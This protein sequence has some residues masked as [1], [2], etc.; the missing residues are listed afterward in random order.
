M[1]LENIPKC[2]VFYDAAPPIYNAGIQVELNK[3]L[4]NELKN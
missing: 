4:L 1:F 3:Y 2:F